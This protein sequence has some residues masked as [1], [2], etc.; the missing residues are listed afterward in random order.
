MTMFKFTE[1]FPISLL[2]S[3][4]CL[5]TASTQMSNGDFQLKKCP[6]KIDFTPELQLH[7]LVKNIIVVNGASR[8]LPLLTSC[9]NPIES[10]LLLESEPGHFSHL[11]FTALVS[12]STSASNI[13]SLLYSKPS[14][15]SILSQQNSKI[16]HEI[17]YSGAWLLLCFLLV[18]LPAQGV[19]STQPPCFSPSIHGIFP[20]TGLSSCLYAQVLP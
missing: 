1:T 16:A 13:P 4:C 9:S 8:L 12:A 10:T 14:R 6:N 5:F 15:V 18:T 19:P 3:R 17:S 11:T 2:S 20:P 7:V